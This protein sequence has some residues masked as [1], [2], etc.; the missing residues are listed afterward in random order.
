MLKIIMEVVN[1]SNEFLKWDH[2]H[3][4]PPHCKVMRSKLIYDEVP[5]LTVNDFPC[6]SKVWHANTSQS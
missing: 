2:Q 5:K 4:Y 1:A 3:L 6:L